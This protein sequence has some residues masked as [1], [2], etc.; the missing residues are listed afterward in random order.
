MFVILIAFLSPFFHALAGIIE[1]RLLNKFFKH[2]APM[3]F[4]ASL[5]SFLFLPFLFLFGT[6]TLTSPTAFC[7][8][9]ILAAI[10]VSYLWPYYRALRK[11]DTSVVAALFS[12]GQIT[13]PILTWLLLNEKLHTSQ[14]IG[15]FII[16]TSSVILSINNFRMPKLNQAFYYMLI[17]SLIRAFYVVLEKYVLTID[18]NWINLMIYTNIL[19]VLL[20]FTLLL[21]KQMRKRIKKGL[22][23]YLSNLS[24]FSVNEL[25]CFLEMATAV[26][27]LSRLSA[28][29]SASINASAPIFLLGISLILRKTFHARLRESLTP[30]IMIKKLICF[31]GIISGIILV[32]Q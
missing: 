15:F 11:M 30:K 21:H 8:Y 23:P 6:P 10:D 9:F 28:V 13:I 25:F 2:P 14:Y 27:A 4:Y 17:V 19:T 22:Q 24:F 16:I 7:C 3:L 1:C 31:S 12:L 5:M 26:F 20:P 32:V 29:T 18:D